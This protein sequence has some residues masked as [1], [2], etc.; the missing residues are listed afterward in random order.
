M[1]GPMSRILVVED[2]AD[3]SDALQR[4]LKRAGH[5]VDC[6]PNGQ[7][8]L[9]AVLRRTP[10]LVVLDLAM[11][12]MDGAELLE[13]F[14]SYL[15]LQALPVVVW[16]GMGNHPIVEKAATF[17]VKAVIPKGGPDYRQLLS[18]V[19]RTLDSPS[20]TSPTQT[21]PADL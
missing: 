8:A 16:T 3:S 20:S 14:R 17:N 6:V 7:A 9:G 13:I 18:A 5:E 1:L 2:D 19:K 11:P 4:L 10:D 15:R 21:P 12:E